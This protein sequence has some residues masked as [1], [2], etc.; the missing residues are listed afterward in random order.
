[1]NQATRATRETF[2]DKVAVITGAASGI[3]LGLARKAA[4]LGMRVALADIE[5]P[6]LA[7]AL[8][9]V[10]A[11]G[12]AAIGV[13]TDVARLESVTELAARVERSLG[14]PWLVV[15]N[16]GVAKMGLSWQLSEAD[17]RWILDV[18]LNGTVYGI[19]TFVPGLVERDSGYVVN[20]SAAAGLLGVPGGAPYVASK[21]AIAG[22]SESLYR[23]LQALKS[24][25]GVSVVCAALVNT[26]I[27]HAERNRPGVAV[28]PAPAGL[29]PL[30]PGV[31]PQMLNLLQPEV[32][33]D[34]VFD[35]VACRRF[36]V[37]PH[38]E[39][40]K[41][42]VSTRTA[43]IFDGRN[44]DQTSMDRVSA[45]LFGMMAGTSFLE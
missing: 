15:N 35:A 1:M 12:V 42:S 39:Q 44:P 38:A 11:E 6:A 8:D 22:L 45:L 30:P 36:W 31:T 2:A 23:E 17:W 21:H 13:K 32:V 34:R 20:M 43:Q 41:P 14:P 19:L 5:E 24:A 3:G 40:L 25:V 4:S 9:L 28:A 7:A 10:K 37:L 26:S 16:A 33:A 18:N 27:A 29:P